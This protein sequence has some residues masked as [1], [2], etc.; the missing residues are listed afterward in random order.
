MNRQHDIPEKSKILALLEVLFPGV[1]VYLFGSRARRDNVPES[2][3][4]LALDI[5]REMTFFELGQARNVL[6]GLG[7]PE[8]IDVLDINSIEERFKNKI[9]TKGVIWKN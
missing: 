4:D 2:D 5:G 6:E 3:I 8:K 9:L 7:L 1:K